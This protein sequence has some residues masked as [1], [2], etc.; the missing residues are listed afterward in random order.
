MPLTD[1][2]SNG[3]ELVEDPIYR[4]SLIEARIIL[5]I[6]AIALV[7]T[8]TYCYLFGYVSHPADPA[9]T[10]PAISELIGPLESFDRDPA[11]L[12]T[13]FGLGIPDWIFFGVAAPWLACIV[14]TIV[15][16]LFFFRA[17]DL[18]SES[19]SATAAGAGGAS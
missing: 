8:C 1:A 17:D 13:P 9:A 3:S 2:E 5:S 15:F 12:K 18:G 7:Y 4:R 6:W 19:E 11:S 10:G 14:V 16:C